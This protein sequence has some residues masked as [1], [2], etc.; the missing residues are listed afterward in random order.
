[1][2]ELTDLELAA[3]QG[4]LRVSFR[5]RR[6]MGEELERRHGLS[7]ADYDVLVRL[8]ERPGGA[9]RMAELADAVFQ[10]RSSLTRIVDGLERRGLVRREPVPDDARGQRAVLTSTGRRTFRRA[11]RTHLSNVQAW[12]VD[13][14]D[15]EQ[16]GQLATIWSQIEQ[17]RDRP[18]A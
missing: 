8:A 16:L 17:P 9:L 1:M 4:L 15:T 2:G 5:L 14:L 13:R 18:A 10:P 3:W 11:Q 7:M 6:D 12:F